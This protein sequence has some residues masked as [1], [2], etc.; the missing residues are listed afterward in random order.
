[1]TLLMFILLGLTLFALALALQ[2]RVLIAASLRQALAAN[3]GDVPN[4]P[5]YRR[6][7]ADAGRAVEHTKEAAYLNKTFPK[8]LAHLGL[9]RRVSIYA[10][11]LII[12][13]LAILRLGVGA[14]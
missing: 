3:F 11:P 4:A 5:A 14:F 7:V 10:L 13:E 6:G 8:P 12:L 1:M 2:M 9:A